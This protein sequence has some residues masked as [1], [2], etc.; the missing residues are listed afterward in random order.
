MLG[1][2]PPMFNHRHRLRPSRIAHQLSVALLLAACGL[3]GALTFW[4]GSNGANLLGGL[5]LGLALADL[6]AILEERWTRL[7]P[8]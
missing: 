7:E 6:M 4:P 5:V 8:R 3:L 2:M 1:I